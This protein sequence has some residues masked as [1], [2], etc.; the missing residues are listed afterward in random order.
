M[1]KPSRTVRF[2][3]KYRIAWAWITLVLYIAAI[4][5]TIIIFPD[6]NMWLALIE[7]FTAF[8]ASL[9]TLGDLLVSAEES[10]KSD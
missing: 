3:Q 6:N 7:L 8:T 2:I 1:R 4:P 10:E 9:T 5:F